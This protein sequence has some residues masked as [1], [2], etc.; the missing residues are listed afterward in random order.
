MDLVSIISSAF[1]K[2]LD[3]LTDGLINTVT[4]YFNEET[5]Y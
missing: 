4:N 5:K 2:D 1:P 3:L